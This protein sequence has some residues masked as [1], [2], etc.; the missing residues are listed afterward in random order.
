MQT[1]ALKI[2][3]KNSGRSQAGVVWAGLCVDFGGRAFPD[4][5]WSDFVAVVLTRW[6]DA[7]VSLLRGKSQRQEV[8]FMEGPFAVVVEVTAAGAWRFTC[9]ER[10]LR[11]VT[12]EQGTIEPKELLSSVVSCAEIALALCQSNGWWSADADALDCG[13]RA[14]KKQIVMRTN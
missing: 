13:L 14:L 3:P 5:R 10:G 7:L 6:V 8:M 12:K 4:P 1:I 11:N 9:I 2:D